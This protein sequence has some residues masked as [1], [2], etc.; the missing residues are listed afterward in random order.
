M[1]HVFAS[2]WNI[3]EKSYKT[4]NSENGLVAKSSCSGVRQLV[5]ESKVCDFIAV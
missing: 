1:K 2:A 5:F 4:D 3:S